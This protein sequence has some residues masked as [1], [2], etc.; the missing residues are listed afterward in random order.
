M[1]DFLAR[2]ATVRLEDA[3]RGKL[4]QLVADHVLGDVHGDKRLAVMHAERVPDKVRR[5]GRTTGP[6]LDRFLG[7]R[8]NR[9][10]DFF[11]KV[12]VNE[13]T[14]L[15]G[16]CHGAKGAGLLLT[17]RLTAVMVNNDLSV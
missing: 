2:H 6:G 13:E 1:L 11:E 16:T 3:R 17:A 7:A 5:D 4:A 9:L 14:L 12:V 15:D 8:L 10:L